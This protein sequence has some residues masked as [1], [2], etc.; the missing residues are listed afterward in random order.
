[1][2]PLPKRPNQTLQSLEEGND[3]TIEQ[4]ELVPRPITEETIFETHIQ[5]EKA[6]RKELAER[7]LAE[8]LQQKKNKS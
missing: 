4:Q 2:P 1:M 7:A 3:D 5:S 6:R 8:R